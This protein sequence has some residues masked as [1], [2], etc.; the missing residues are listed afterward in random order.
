MTNDEEVLFSYVV[1]ANSQKMPVW[2][3]A[4]WTSLLLVGIIA[5]TTLAF[6]NWSL[7]QSFDVMTVA[8]MIMSLVFVGIQ[9][10]LCTVYR[11]ATNVTIELSKKH[12]IIKGVTSSIPIKEVKASI[13]EGIQLTDS[14][15]DIAV[16]KALII[17][18]QELS[19]FLTIGE[20]QGS[21]FPYHFRDRI[22]FVIGKHIS[23]EQSKTFIDLVQKLTVA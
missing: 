22:Q 5:F 3:F 10:W 7:S 20:A 19:R 14:G 8:P 12:F 4:L 21:L 1:S 11:S 18:V 16:G 13:G 2:I 15:A 6:R 23:A 9:F 17:E